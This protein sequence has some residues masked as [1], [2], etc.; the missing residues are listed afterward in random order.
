MGSEGRDGRDGGATL[1]VIVVSWNTRPLLENCLRSLFAG[2]VDG[3]TEVFVVDNASGDG[4]AAMVRTFFPD[5]RLL[6]TGENLG[7]ARA[8]NRALRQADARY[9][10][11]LN[12]D[13]IVPA[14]TLRQLVEVAEA[15]PRVA[16]CG[17]LLLNEDGSPQFCWARFP[18][19]AFEWSGRHDL[20]QSPYPLVD[21]ADPERRSRMK[22][23]VADWVGGACLLVRSSALR[24]V[25]LLDEG[26]F[27][28]TEETDWCYRFRAAGYETLCV[29]SVTVTHLGGGSSRLVPERTRDR[30]YRSRLRFYRKWY[31]PIGSLAPCLMA[32]LRHRASLLRS[33]RSR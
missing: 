3:G 28:Y 5:V 25:G 14:G 2:N 31:G 21:F 24:Q 22:P 27:M 4:S 10:L 1:A 13:T 30:M 19:A 16:A 9:C 15:S 26:Y 7:F 6:Q 20:S 18:G 32:T 12:P 29:P 23:F 11:L 8:N 33:G 17:P